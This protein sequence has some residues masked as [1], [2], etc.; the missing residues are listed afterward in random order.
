M[1]TGSREWCSSGMSSVPEAMVTETLAQIAH[2]PLRF[3]SHLSNIHL[4][5]GTEHVQ[6]SHTITGMAHL[7]HTRVT[8]YMIDK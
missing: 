7:L 1:D 3:P 2:H 6:S 8:L 4:E 5:A